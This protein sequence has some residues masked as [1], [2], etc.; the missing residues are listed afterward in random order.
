MGS[1]CAWWRI[2]QGP[3]G[4]VPIH[5]GQCQLSAKVP[6]YLSRHNNQGGYIARRCP[7]R[8]QWDFLQPGEALPLSLQLRASVSYYLLDATNPRP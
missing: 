2:G 8:A 1:N 6:S 4:K 7:V 3:A 5:V